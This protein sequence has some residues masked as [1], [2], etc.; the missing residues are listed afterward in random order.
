[1][2]NIKVELVGHGDVVVITSPDLA[3]SLVLSDVQYVEM[4]KHLIQQ[5]KPFTGCAIKLLSVKTER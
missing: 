1:M 2:A 3:K 4:T 5:A